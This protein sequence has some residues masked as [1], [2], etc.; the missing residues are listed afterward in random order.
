MIKEYLNFLA[1]VRN[2]A[3]STIAVYNRQ[4]RSFAKFLVARQVCAWSSVATGDVL[5]FI[6]A[7]RCRAMA[8]ASCNMQLAVVSGFFDWLVK[9]HGLASNPCLLVGRM[10]CPKRLPQCIE[11]ATI[12]RVIESLSGADFKTRLARFVVSSLY[13][14][15]LRA[16]ELLSLRFPAVPQG[17]VS[18][19]IV[20]KGNKERVVPISADFRAEF[21]RWQSYVALLLGPEASKG[22]CVVAPGGK[23]LC[24][25]S[26]H[27]VVVFALSPFV[28]KSLCHPHAL[29]HSFAT[30]LLS[31]GVD[32][33][34]IQRLLGHASINTTT[35][36]TTL[37]DNY[38]TS[39]FSKAFK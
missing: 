35:I 21:D 36:Y 14:C 38:I 20:G 19:R 16:S 9:F 15:G 30:F 23:P 5:A 33:Q 27:K 28:E 18:F 29:R 1:S 32:L 17:A 26:L 31:Q 12:R 25:R 37:S 3:P 13:F 39:Q 11:D 22:F 10:K 24:K 7:L 8:P 2:C 4:L 34:V 6:E